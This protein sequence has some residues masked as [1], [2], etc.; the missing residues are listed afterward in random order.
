MFILLLVNRLCDTG[1]GLSVHLLHLFKQD[2]PE[3]GPQYLTSV[4]HKNPPNLAENLQLTAKLLVE[5]GYADRLLN[6]IFPPDM[7][8]QT[9]ASPHDLNKALSKSP[10]KSSDKLSSAAVSLIRHLPL[11]SFETSQIN[12]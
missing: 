10:I 4:L 11:Q 6:F 3:V 12:R 5:A 9:S 1:L 7:S 2:N 8:A